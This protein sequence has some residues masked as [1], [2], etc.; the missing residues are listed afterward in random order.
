[1]R[2]TY[3]AVVALAVWAL[4]VFAEE[5]HCPGAYDG[6]LQG[7]AVDDAGNLYWSFTVALVKTDAAGALLR[8]ATVPSHHGDLWVDCGMVYAAVNHPAANGSV[9]SRDSWIYA[10]NKDDLSL[11]WKKEIPEVVQ[12]AGGLAMRE[13]RFF[14]VS[15]RLLKPDAK[16]FVYEYDADCTFVKRHLLDSGHTHLGIQTMAYADGTWWFGCYG[17]PP[18]TLRASEDLV[19]E[20]RFDCDCSVGIAPVPGGGFYLGRDKRTEERKNIG[21]I[22]KVDR[23]AP[24]E[25]KQAE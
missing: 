9:V 3:A 10:Y 23:P 20:E 21:W 7:I 16:N 25:N 18:E 17:A 5:L 6:H 1:M 15:G 8:K 11:A 2:H 12:G 19:F 22:I 4:P 14:V 13:G 24:A